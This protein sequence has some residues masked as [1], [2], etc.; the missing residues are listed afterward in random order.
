MV[1]A[2]CQ[3]L[4]SRAALCK[5]KLLIPCRVCAA[6]G[7]DKRLLFLR[8]LAVKDQK[9]NGRSDCHLFAPGNYQGVGCRLCD[10]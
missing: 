5:C 9:V 7:N 6:V 2:D 10:V 8:C 3:R 4:L 1:C